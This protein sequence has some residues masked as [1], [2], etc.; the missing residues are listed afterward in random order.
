[1]DYLLLLLLGILWGTAPILAKIVVAEVPVFT[2]V[3]GRLTL[4]AA[5]LWLILRL[6]GERMPTDRR[7][8]TIYALQ[9]IFN[10]AVPFCL[11][12]WAVQSIP[13]G[14]AALLQATTPIFTLLL[15]HFFIGAERF[16]PA[17]VAG[18]LLGF[19]GVLLQMISTLQVGL[20]A[21]LW[22]QM[23]VILACILFGA[24]AIASRRF[25]QG[26]PPLQSATGALTAGAI[27]LWPFAL[28]I[29]QPFTISPGMPVIIS[30]LALA[31]LASV[32]ART[33]YF[34]IVNRTSATFVTMVMYIL[35]ITGLI[36]GAI[37]LGEALSLSLLASL[38]LILAG[39]FLVN[40]PTNS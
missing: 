18:V 4:A 14:L 9:G 5:L 6:R 40:R 17:R 35:P 30:W 32:V 13:G 22:G 26:Q 15:A 27:F 34:T 3:G 23:A 28:L 2:L 37:L 12:S 11:I 20:T 21:N 16:T 24:M 25:M 38:A 10:A 8:W 19:A 33:V 39:I 31:L 7:S 1:M 36:V 29:D